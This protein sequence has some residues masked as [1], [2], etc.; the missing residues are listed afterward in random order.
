MPRDRESPAI[1]QPLRPAVFSDH[2]SIP[3]VDT[4]YLCEVENSTG[5][6]RD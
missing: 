1:V 3:T 4:D 5:P 6:K 2:A